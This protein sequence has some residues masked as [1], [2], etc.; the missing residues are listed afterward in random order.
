MK[1]PLLLLTALKSEHKGGWWYAKYCLDNSDENGRTRNSLA[2]E[3]ARKHRNN[4]EELLTLYSTSESIDSIIIRLQKLRDDAEELERQFSGLC[5]GSDKK[6][7]NNAYA[8]HVHG[9]CAKR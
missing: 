1:S 6:A 3:A 4:A 9:E 2:E 5:R 7:W 8:A